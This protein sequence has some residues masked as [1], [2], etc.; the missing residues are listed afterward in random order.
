MTDQL[1]FSGPEAPPGGARG[2]AHVFKYCSVFGCYAAHGGFQVIP[3]ISL[4]CSCVCP[5]NLCLLYFYLLQG[6]YFFKLISRYFFLPIIKG[7]LLIYMHSK[8]D[9]FYEVKSDY[10]KL[11]MYC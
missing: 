8:I 9:V 11:E 6:H 3:I 1:L 5:I 4:L 7:N 10:T 2:S